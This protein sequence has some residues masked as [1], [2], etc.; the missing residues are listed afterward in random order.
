MSSAL[1]RS[2]GIIVE[3]ISIIIYVANPNSQFRRNALYA[4]VGSVS[5]IS[6]ITKF[7]LSFYC[8]EKRGQ[9]RRLGHD[10]NWAMRYSLEISS[11]RSLR[12]SVTKPHHAYVSLPRQPY[13]Q[14]KYPKTIIEYLLRIHLPT[15]WG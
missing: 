3:L 2:E 4:L 1:G 5:S 7:P 6:A 11:S 14:E 12:L 15:V 10:W 8:S 13:K 9:N